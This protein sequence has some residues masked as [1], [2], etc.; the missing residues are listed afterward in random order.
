MNWAKI[1]DEKPRAEHTR[2]ELLILAARDDRGLQQQ[3]M[4][5]DQKLKDWTLF[6]GF[7]MRCFEGDIENYWT[8]WV[9][10]SGP[11]V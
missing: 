5:W 6:D 8:D 1:L 11:P 10:I 7:S 2:G 4:R 3:P 9:I